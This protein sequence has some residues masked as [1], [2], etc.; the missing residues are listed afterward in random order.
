MYKRPV[1]G[2]QQTLYG[3]ARFEGYTKDLADSLSQELNLKFEIRPVKDGQYGVSDP[4]VPGGWTGMIGELVRNEADIAISPL[5]IN[6]HREQVVDFTVPFM[7]AGIS[8]MMKRSNMRSMSLF[9]FLSPLSSEIWTSLMFAYLGVSIV[10][11]LVSRFSPCEWRIE[12]TMMGT[13]VKNPFSIG[14]SLFFALGTFMHQYT[15]L[16]PRS[17]AGR[18]VGG[19]WWFFSLIIIAA[20]TSNMAAFLTIERMVSFIAPVTHSFVTQPLTCSKNCQSIRSMIF[21]TKP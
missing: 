6:A 13:R 12:E 18:L 15:A 7:P 14:N 4:N 8:I 5:T 19:A 11:F 3:N 1:P 17:I 20:Y 2:Q 9:S 10:L 16:A 21:H